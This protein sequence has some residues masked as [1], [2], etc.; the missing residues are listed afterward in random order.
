VKLDTVI[1]SISKVYLLRKGIISW[2]V[3]PCAVNK[4]QNTTYSSRQ[5]ILRNSLDDIEGVPKT[6]Y[7]LSAL[8]LLLLM[9]HFIRFHIS[10]CTLR[11]HIYVYW[12][13]VLKLQGRAGLHGSVF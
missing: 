11:S 8:I 1:F 2:I 10:N 3:P 13:P 12:Q 6:T 7:N 4:S 5:I 9:S